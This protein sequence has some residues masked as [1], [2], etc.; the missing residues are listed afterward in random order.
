MGAL[1]RH[2]GRTKGGLDAE[3]HAIR[4]GAGRP[5]VLLLSAGQMSDHK[6]ACLV[7]DAL[8]AA[9]TPIADRGYGSRPFR[10]ALTE[11]E[12]VPCIPSS[13]RRKRPYRF[14][15]TLDRERHGIDDMFDRLNDWRKVA[16]RYDRCAH[17]FMNAI[18]LAATLVF[19]PRH[20]S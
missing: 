17:T 18:C 14:D 8:S 7:L 9:F 16:T 2:H 4:D 20:G 1:S 12:I 13:R 6:G 5:V 3:L 19:W 11:R 10:E 15:K